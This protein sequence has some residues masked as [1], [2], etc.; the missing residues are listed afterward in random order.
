MRIC[1]DGLHFGSQETSHHIGALQAGHLA[2]LPADEGSLVS[3]TLEPTHAMANVVP[4]GIELGST[5][6]DR[7]VV[8]AV[9]DHALLGFDFLRLVRHDLAF[10]CEW[11]LQLAMRAV[12][13][14]FGRSFGSFFSQLPRHLAIVPASLVAELRFRGIQK[15]IVM[16][17]R[18]DGNVQVCDLGVIGQCLFRSCIGFFGRI[19]LPSP[20]VEDLSLHD[21]S[22]WEWDGSA[23]RVQ[24]QGEHDRPTEQQNQTEL[25]S[26]IVLL[27]DRLKPIPN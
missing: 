17:I 18:N 22:P 6:I 26:R 24:N 14:V 21:E 9:D 11:E 2:I 27:H 23:N 20:D 12:T 8:L 25:E 19:G 7:S 15:R 5:G 16:L 4:L 10:S 3:L 1:L 13:D